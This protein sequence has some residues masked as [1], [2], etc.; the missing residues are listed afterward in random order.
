MRGVAIFL[1]LLNGLLMI[2]FP[3]LV[4]YVLL[5]RKGGSFRPIWIG[6]VGFIL[7]QVGHIPFNQFLLLPGLERWGVELTARSG[8]DLWILG[9]SLG[10]SAGVFEEVVRYLA[11]RFWLKEERGEVL[12]WKYGVGH[13]GVEAILTGLITL[14]AFVQVL[15]LSGEGVLAG[16]P[17]EEAEAIRFQLDAY[18][19]VPWQLTLL[20]AWERVSALLFHLGASV[21]VYKSFREKNPLW[22]L[23]AVGGH[24]GMNAFAVVAVVKMDLVLLEL[25]LF[26]FAL[27]WIS[28][29][30]Y[31]RPRGEEEAE[32]APPPPEVDL[33][34][35]QITSKQLEESRYD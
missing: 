1:R 11:F 15:T 16:F 5:R 10:L 21:F 34:V 31:V 35:S 12:P 24:T 27:L 28:W 30:W 4:G 13:G 32:L 23:V 6:V 2:G 20:G 17:A 19:S 26:V 3:C 22:F 14:Y 8:G 9:I 25:L 29:A 18:W 7:S 33:S